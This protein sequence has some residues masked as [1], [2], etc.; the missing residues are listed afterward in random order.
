VTSVL[1]TDEGIEK[2]TM[3][4]KSRTDEKH[5]LPQARLSPIS[6][7][8]ADQSRCKERQHMHCPLLGRTLQKRTV[9]ETMD[10]YIDTRNWD[11]VTRNLSCWSV[12]W[13]QPM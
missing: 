3:E 4:R 1:K 12:T 6:A 9:V 13:S 5:A 11:L 8:I 10:C 2:L 7:C